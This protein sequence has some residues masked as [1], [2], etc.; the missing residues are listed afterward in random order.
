MKIKRLCTIDIEIFKTIN[1]INPNFMKDIFTPKRDPKIRPYDI[2]VK[3]HK[4]AK[5]G[6]KSLIALG[7]KIWNQL[8]SNVKSLTFITKLKEYIRTYFGPSCKS[9]ICT[10]I[11]TQQLLLNRL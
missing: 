2:F 4:S 5:Y 10:M 8:L 3:H 1:N 6:D 7:P 11:N 9:N